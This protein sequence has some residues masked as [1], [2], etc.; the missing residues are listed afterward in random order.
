M[1]NDKNM[2]LEYPRSL[3]MRIALLAAVCLY[4]CGG[5]GGGD[6]STP[7]VAGFPPGYPDIIRPVVS[8]TSPSIGET[9][10]ALNSS[11]SVTFSEPMNNGTLNSTTFNLKR[12]TGNV[13]VS[14]SVSVNSNAATFVPGTAL[15]ANTQYTAT[16]TTDV[17]DVAGN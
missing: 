10:V 13:P 11:V 3:I 1:S 15:V 14:G 2:T 7:L 5:G 9:G 8:D 12:T 6:G 16:V 17:R 4:G